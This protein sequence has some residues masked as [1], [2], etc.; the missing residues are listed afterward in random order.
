MDIDF[1]D[2]LV[3]H[4]S[5]VMQLE[6]CCLG[7]RIIFV[8]NWFHFIFLSLGITLDFPDFIPPFNLYTS[9]TYHQA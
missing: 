6:V 3:E 7:E 5:V 1:T 8:F 4:K 9:H 2:D